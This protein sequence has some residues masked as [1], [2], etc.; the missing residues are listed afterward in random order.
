MTHKE[1]KKSI[2][3]FNRFNMAILPVQ[4]S[5]QNIGQIMA[6]VGQQSVEGQRVGFGYTKELFISLKMIMVQRAEICKE[7]IQFRIESN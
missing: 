6:V 5:K 4:G 7:L 3:E 2:S 1:V